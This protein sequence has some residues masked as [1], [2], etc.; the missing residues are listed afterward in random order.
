MPSANFLLYPS[1]RISGI[2]ICENTTAPATV[3]PVIAE[4][5]ALPATVAMP[6]PPRTR[7]SSASIELNRSRI[8]PDAVAN[9]PIRM[10]SGITAKM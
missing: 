6:S 10:N 3:T 9:A 4:N 1:R 8:T 5:T 2:E 7:W